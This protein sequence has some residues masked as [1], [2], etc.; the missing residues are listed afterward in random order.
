MGYAKTKGTTSLNDLFGLNLGQLMGTSKLVNQRQQMEAYLDWVYA[1]STAI[2][3][4]AA[5]IEFRAYANRTRKKSARIANQLTYHPAEA[6]R[7]LKLRAGNQP[8]LEE[9]DNHVLLDLLDNPNPFMDRESFMELTFLHLQLAGEAF[10]GKIRNG[11]HKPE[12]LWPMMPYN[13][14]HVANEGEFISGWVY[15]VGAEDVPWAVEDVVHIKLVDPNNFRRGM[16]VVRAA[17]R[18]IDTDS[19]AADWNRNFFQNSA[20]PDY[21]LETDQSLSETVYSRL[22]Q[23]WDDRHKG[24]INA[25][26]VGILEAGLKVNRTTLTQKDMDFLKSREFNKDQILA[27]F[28]VSA[29][30]LGLTTNHN[31]ANMEA[32]DYNHAKRVIKPIMSKPAAAINNQL[33]PDF[34]QKLVIGFTDPVPEDKAFTLKEQSE[35]IDKFWTR[36]EVRE[37]RGLDP[38]PGGEVMYIPSSVVPLTKE[39]AEYQEPVMPGVEPDA[40][41]PDDEKPKDGDKPEGEKGLGKSRRSTPTTT[42]AS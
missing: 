3:R 1:A 13:M 4:E 9:L 28:G 14:K 8:A 19:H 15:R 27:M 34:D 5:T 29:S 42:N 2:A 40:G 33:A 36:N 25:H 6:A 24:T 23:Q 20:R 11:L 30:I 17:A 22:K 32:A 7:L 18:A 37:L 38:V 35:G 39:S 21:V 26:K 41:E 10:W 16:S 12:Q 31:R